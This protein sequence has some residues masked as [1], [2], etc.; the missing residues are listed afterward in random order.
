[1]GPATLK[2]PYT[3]SVKSKILAQIMQQGQFTY[4]IAQGSD[5]LTIASEEQTPIA[6]LEQILNLTTEESKNRSELS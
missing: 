6:H 5:P 3:R 2:K 1:M 4:P